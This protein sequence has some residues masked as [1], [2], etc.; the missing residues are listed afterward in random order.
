MR[1]YPNK[2]VENAVHACVSS[3]LDQVERAQ[4]SICSTVEAIT[5]GYYIVWQVRPS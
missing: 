2:S 1:T 5:L 3:L 4:G